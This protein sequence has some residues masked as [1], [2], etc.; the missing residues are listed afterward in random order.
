MESLEPTLQTAPQQHSLELSLANLGTAPHRTW[1]HSNGR[2]T[3]HFSWYLCN[4]HCQS[5][6][7]IGHQTR[8]PERLR[9]RD[10]WEK[11]CESYWGETKQKWVY[12]RAYSNNYS[13]PRALYVHFDGICVLATIASHFVW[14][15]SILVEISHEWSS[16]R[17]SL[18][19]GNFTYEDFSTYSSYREGSRFRVYTD[20]VEIR[21]FTNDVP[22]GRS[23][24]LG[25]WTLDLGPYHFLRDAWLVKKNYPWCV[26]RWKNSAWYV[27]GTPP[28]PPSSKC[29]N[30]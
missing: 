4:E 13:D 15:N 3:K 12:L 8:I 6:S 17:R 7:C 19:K 26:I 27:I 30:V 5:T 29:Q 14:Y 23:K 28:L 21:V 9:R 22:L 2:C 20:W 1:M 16:V 18:R 25:P 11:D 24:D 10:N